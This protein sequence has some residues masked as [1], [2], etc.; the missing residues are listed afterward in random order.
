MRMTPKIG[1]DLGKDHAQIKIAATRA[2]LQGNA[3]TLHEHWLAAKPAPE[4]SIPRTWTSALTGGHTNNQAVESV[5][6]LDLA[7]QP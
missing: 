1:M 4:K 7:G 3:E 6:H 5:A 2:A